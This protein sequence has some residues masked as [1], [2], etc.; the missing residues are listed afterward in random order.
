M[1]FGEI[2]W[3]EVGEDWCIKRGRGASKREMII[4]FFCRPTVKVT[5]GL[6]IFNAKSIE[7]SVYNIF[8]G[9]RTCFFQILDTA[10]NTL[11][12][13]TI[14]CYFHTVKKTL[15]IFSLCENY[16]RYSFDI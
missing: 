15:F 14:A 1:K 7:F 9:F 6:Y 16:Y 5:S 2:F 3:G 8:S 13:F 4:I 11:R 12:D 10:Y